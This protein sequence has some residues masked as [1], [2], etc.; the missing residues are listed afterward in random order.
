MPNLLVLIEYFYCMLP[1]A[2]FE[3]FQG[4]PDAS[5]HGG[6]DHPLSSPWCIA[7]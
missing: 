5:G 4:V 2:G 1:C 6:T 7:V 3:A